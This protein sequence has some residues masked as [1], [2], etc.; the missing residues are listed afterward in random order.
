MRIR[1]LFVALFAVL[2][3]CTF[4]FAQE[5]HKYLHISTNPSYADAYVNNVRAKIASNPDVELPGFVEVPEGDANVTVKLFKAGY[6]DTTIN[7]TLSDADTSYLIVA[8]TPSYD[9]GYLQFQQKSLMRRARNNL[10]HRLIIASAVPLIASG[11]SAIISNSNITKAEDKKDLVE[12]SVIREG[13]DYESNLEDFDRY[14]DR[15]KAAKNVSIG[16]AI[17]GGIILGFGIVLSF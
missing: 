12:K 1:L 16:T 4:S 9:D 5:G 11:I 17:A 15:A 3:A 2:L 7:V 6:R 14:R 10:G 8:L 13:D